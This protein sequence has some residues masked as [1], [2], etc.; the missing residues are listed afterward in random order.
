MEGP[1]RGGG[2]AESL[3]RARIRASGRRADWRTSIGAA[4]RSGGRWMVG[5]LADP[6]TA[7]VAPHAPALRGHVAA[8]VLFS[9][10]AAGASGSRGVGRRND[11]AGADAQGG[12]R[13]F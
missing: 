3:L 6:P 10:H 7:K 12:L 13:G 8:Q 9:W 4:G 11:D 1:R 5:L 2:G